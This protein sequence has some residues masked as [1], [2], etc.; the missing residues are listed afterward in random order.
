MEQSAPLHSKRLLDMYDGTGE[1][2][3]IGS[4]DALGSNAGLVAVVEKVPP[5]VNDSL[6]AVEDDKVLI[7]D[8]TGC[9]HEHQLATVLPSPEISC[10]IPPV[11]LYHARRRLLEDM[12]LPSGIRYLP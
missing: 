6:K 7:R 1:S 11:T 4:L 3:L 5:S 9:C 12:N 10:D 8:C 2:I